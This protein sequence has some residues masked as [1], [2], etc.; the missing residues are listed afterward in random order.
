MTTS[1]TADGVTPGKY[2]VFVR[3][4]DP[5]GETTGDENRDDIVVKITA[6]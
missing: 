5:S 2:V 1:A 6:D 4:T 3:A